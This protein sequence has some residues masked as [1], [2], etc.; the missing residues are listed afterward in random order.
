MYMVQSLQCGRGQE[1]GIGA[2]R[3]TPQAGS[4]YAGINATG[5]AS[6]RERPGCQAALA[7][8]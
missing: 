4:F 7:L 1:K 3:L 8:R 6:S 2:S 5:Y